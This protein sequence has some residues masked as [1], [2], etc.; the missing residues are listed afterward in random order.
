M[1]EISRHLI[2]HLPQVFAYYLSLI[3]NSLHLYRDPTMT[4]FAF[5]LNRV[6]RWKKDLVT[7]WGN[8][9]I[10]PHL[11]HLELP[12]HSPVELTSVSRFKVWG[13]TQDPCHNMAYLLV[14]LGNTIEGTQYG[15]SLVLVNPK[16]A[17][18]PMMEE[19]VK[20]LATYPSSGANW[21]YILV[22]LYEGSCHALLHKGKHLGILPQRKA[23]KTSCG[24]IS[25][26]DI[27]Q[28][29]S[30]GPQVVYPSGLNEVMSPL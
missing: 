14:H 12:S 28:L 9:G 13:N 18:A 17:R 1:R 16:Q 10:C 7:L 21:S 8:L 29:L 27:C 5:F 15:V 26:L 19:A 6:E 20:K 22:Q 25:Q 11:N 23:E 30:A 4:E 24:Q 2:W 3:I